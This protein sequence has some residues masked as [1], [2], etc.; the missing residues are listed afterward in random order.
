MKQ[1]LA[2]SVSEAAR[3]LGRIID[4]DGLG[5]TPVGGND[6]GQRRAV[7]Q[8]HDDVIGIVLPSDVER[9]DDVRMRKLR[10]RFGLLVEAPNELV[11]GCVLLSQHLD[12]DPAAEQRIGA[13]VHGGHP[14]LTELAIEAVAVIENPLFDQLPEFPMLCS[15]VSI[16]SLAIGA[17]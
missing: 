4:R 16:T 15:A 13:A 9:V 6:L 7:D 14:A 17:A 8:L 11:V 1:P 10:G 12:G 2:V 5:Q 3:D